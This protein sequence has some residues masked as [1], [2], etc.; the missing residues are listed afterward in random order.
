MLHGVAQRKRCHDEQRRE[1]FSL[2]NAPETFTATNNMR[3]ALAGRP[4]RGKQGRILPRGYGVVI[5]YFLVIFLRF[6]CFL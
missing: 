6:N 1:G 3:P 2:S 5:R 4:R